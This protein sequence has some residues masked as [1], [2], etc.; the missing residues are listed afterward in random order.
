MRNHRVNPRRGVALLLVIGVMAI[1]TVAAY[2]LLADSAMQAQSAAATN[3]AAQADSLAESGVALAMY[4]VQHPSYAPHLTAG[5]GNIPAY[6]AGASGITFGS[7]SGSATVTV[8]PSG[9]TGQLWTVTSTGNSPASLGGISKTLSATVQTVMGYQVNQPVVSNAN[10]TLSSGSSITG[11]TTASIVSTGTVTINLGAT[12]N[13]SIEASGLPGLLGLLLGILLPPPSSSPALITTQ[14]TDYSQPY[15][16]QGQ[17]YS[18]QVISSPVNSTLGPSAGN[19]A[20]IFVATSNVT[21]STGTINGTIYTKNGA[22]VVFTKTATITPVTGYPGLVVD[23]STSITVA[24]TTVTINGLALFNGGLKVSN[25]SSG[26][27]VN[28][29]LLFGTQGT[30]AGSLGKLT[31]TYNANNVKV[32]FFSNA[33]QFTSPIGAKIIA[34]NP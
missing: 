18:P 11:G 27:T 22:N 1:A 34:W 31:V 32:P 29:A 19:P 8:A 4:Y 15:S 3:G 23:G 20:G 6:W 21:I 33:N 25:G 12:V 30:L 5:S 16:Y 10:I 17:T 28:G 24:S 7:A 14:V 26:I 2:A 9:T 13:G